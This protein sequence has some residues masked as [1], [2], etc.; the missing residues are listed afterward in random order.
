MRP[1]QACLGIRATPTCNKGVEASFNEA[2]ASLPRNTAQYRIGW[3]APMHA[4]MR[5]RQACLGIRPREITGKRLFRASMRPRQACLGIR[6]DE[7]VRLKTK[8]RFNEAEAS[9]PRNTDDWAFAVVP[10]AVAS[11]RPRQACLGILDECARSF[12]YRVRAASMR[13]RQACLGIRMGS[14]GR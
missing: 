9:L 12:A 1:R 10:L 4:S 13:P 14:A 11:M 2:E 6:G 8:I 3:T 5:P 7:P